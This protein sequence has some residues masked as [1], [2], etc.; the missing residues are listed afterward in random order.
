[1]IGKCL[2]KMLNRAADE[3]DPKDRANRPSVQSVL[4]AFVNAIRSAPKQKDSRQEPILEPHYKLVSIV[5]KLVMR[6]EMGLQDAAH[7]LQQQPYAIQKGEAVVVSNIEEWNR[8][9]LGSLRHL[10]NADKQ[11][12]HHRMVARVVQILYNHEK[13]D[14]DQALAARNEFR[15]SMFTKTM[16]IQVWK[17][18][19]ER[20]GRHCVYMSRYVQVMFQ[21]LWTANDKANMEQLARRVKKKANDFFK[22]NEVWADCCVAYIRMIRRSAQ[23]PANMDEAFKAISIEEFEL[24]SDRLTEWIADPNMSHPAL[25]A[26]RETIE[27]KKLNANQM[28]S[29][30]IDDLINDAWAALYTQVAKTLPGADPPSMQQT[31]TDGA[32]DT[33]GPRT[34]GPMS[35]NNVVMNMDGTQ[36]TFPSTVAGPETVRPRKLGISR[37]EILRRAEGAI[38]RASDPPR[39]LAPPQR[40]VSEASPSLTQG[41]NVALSKHDPASSTLKAT[42]P[43]RHII[44][45][46]GRTDNGNVR[47]GSSAPGSLHDSADDESDLSDLSDFPDMDDAD[48]AMIFPNLMRKDGPSGN[49]G[50]EEASSP[51]KD[52]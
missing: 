2:W 52:A 46:S 49:N 21:I 51:A 17:T 7:L 42:T 1:M 5:H 50:G 48:D 45:K 25:D 43:A 3:W 47:E 20:A 33:F 28:K 19:T 15:E 8:F 35:L 31:Q 44:D 22:F 11:H 4:D 9:V 29:A 23:I 39:A 26:L 37:R 41:S 12:W 24:F 27:L 18:E 10:R 13:P 14:Y 6:K 34:V 30:V 32:A 38:A 16:H 40:R 36:N